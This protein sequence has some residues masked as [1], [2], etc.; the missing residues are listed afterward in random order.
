VSIS[1]QAHATISNP[2]DEDWVNVSIALVS[3][4]IQILDD[5]V[6]TKGPAKRAGGGGGGS[7]GGGG[8]GP[9]QLFVKTL[10]G[11]TITLEV[12]GSDSIDTVKQKIQDKEG[13][14]P[15][16]QRLIFAGKQLED[17]RSLSD[18]NIQRDSTLHLVLRL[19]GDGGGSSRAPPTELHD[20]EDP[21]AAGDLA[22]SSVAANTTFTLRNPVSV[23]AHTSTLVPMLTMPCGDAA[24]ST[25]YSGKGDPRS[26]VVL[27]N[28]TSATPLEMGTLAVSLDGAFLG[29]SILSPLKPGEWTTAIYAREPRISAAKAAKQA[30]RPPSKLVFVDK[31]DEAVPSPL[32]ASAVC[33]TRVQTLTTTYTFFNRTGRDCR[34]FL[35]DHVARPGYRLQEGSDAAAA[36]DS[37]FRSP[38]VYRFRM[39]LPAPAPG[40]S[41]KEGA[42]VFTAVEEMDKVDRTPLLQWAK[43]DRVELQRAKL[44]SAEDIRHVE[45]VLKRV[46]TLEAAKAKLD[47]LKA[48]LGRLSVTSQQCDVN[49]IAAA[50]DALEALVLQHK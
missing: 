2:T 16:Q 26:C 45:A 5:N 41:D 13:I 24:V 31:D 19:R 23:P 40:V 15:D 42:F 43:S 6:M 47:S 44:V 11:K 36:L 48:H 17:G 4:D 46:E 38:A 25:L 49:A 30:S 20:D 22:Y 37:R 29:E 33:V 34:D 10:T 9:M 8:G 14:P 35:V 3:G 18:Y 12:N 27:R 21:F 32:S 50:V 7:G 28:T 1:L 39:Q